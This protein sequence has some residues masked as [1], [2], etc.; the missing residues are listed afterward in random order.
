MTSPATQ[1]T[2]KTPCAIDG[3]TIRYVKTGA[4]VTCTLRR[5]VAHQSTSIHEHIASQY[6]ARNRERLH[7][8]PTG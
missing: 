7:R 2:P 6:D 3:S 8:E 4:C 1:F 5:S